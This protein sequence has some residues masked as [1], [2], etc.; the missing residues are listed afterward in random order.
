MI[1]VCGTEKLTNCTKLC[2]PLEAAIKSVVQCLPCNFV[3]IIGVLFALTVRLWRLSGLL[4]VRVNGYARKRLFV[5]IIPSTE[6]FCILVC[7]FIV[8]VS[9]QSIRHTFSDG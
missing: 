7:V 2:C 8:I 9:Y 4:I 3:F 1:W 6:I 5:T